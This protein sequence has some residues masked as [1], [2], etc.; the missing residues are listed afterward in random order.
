M[1]KAGYSKKVQ[2]SGERK[3]ELELNF[4]VGKAI[5]TNTGINILVAGYFGDRCIVA[6]NNQIYN[7]E[8]YFGFKFNYNQLTR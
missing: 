8:I 3:I 4:P 7:V 6:N 5:T 1:A 2:S